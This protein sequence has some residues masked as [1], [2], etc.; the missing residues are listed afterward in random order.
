MIA[1]IHI[2]LSL[3]TYSPVLAYFEEAVFDVGAGEVTDFFRRQVCRVAPRPA[4]FLLDE[5]V[6]LPVAETPFAVG[7]DLYNRGVA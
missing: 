7:D 1:H 6:D 3:N 4:T 2:N 5:R